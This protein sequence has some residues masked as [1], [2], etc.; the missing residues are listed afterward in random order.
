MRKIENKE[1]PREI[2]EV[3]EAE[4]ALTVF[5]YTFPMM[6]FGGV[7]IYIIYE[8]FSVEAGNMFI[9]GIVLV[10]LVFFGVSIDTLLKTPLK[11]KVYKDRLRF[12]FWRNIS[13]KPKRVDFSDITDFQIRGDLYSSVDGKVPLTYIDEGDYSKIA[14]YL[15]DFVE[16]PLESDAPE[17]SSQDQVIRK[18][19]L[20][21][22]YD[23]KPDRSIEVVR[24]KER[25]RIIFGSM[26]LFCLA[27]PI[28]VLIF[29]PLEK[30]VLVSSFLFFFIALLSGYKYYDYNR[31]K[32]FVVDRDGIRLLIDG[33]PEFEAS[34]YSIQK[35]S[36][37]RGRRNRFIGFETREEGHYISIYEF[38]TGRLREAF[39]VMRKYANY[40]DL[41]LENTIRW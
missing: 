13:N 20:D 2:I 4:K 7:I 18:K 31:D 35:I 11:V 19:E 1:K 9:G 17:S 33:E 23:G 34:W 6:I 10:V 29:A 3:E 12:E 28:I 37:H 27:I 38:S 5:K 36:A 15:E 41:E 40:Y 21:L 30:P 16:R 22:K 24:K 25:G 14:K 39:D 8:F 26:F 32:R